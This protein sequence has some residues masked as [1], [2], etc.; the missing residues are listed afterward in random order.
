MKTILSFFIISFMVLQPIIGQTNQDKTLSAP[1]SADQKMPYYDRHQIDISNLRDYYDGLLIAD[2]MIHA[3]AMFSAEDK[4]KM[5]L[6][7]M[8]LSKSNHHQARSAYQLS[9]MD[10]PLREILA[11]WSPTYVETIQDPRMRA[12][13]EYLKQASQLP[14]KVNADTHAALRM[15]YTD[16]QIAELTDLTSVNAANAVHDH[17]LPIATDQETIDWALKNLAPV[18][19]SLGLNASNSKAEQRANPYV[20]ETLEKAFEEINS[21]WQR[22]NL[23]AID[24]E[25]ETDW[26][27]FLTGYGVSPVTFDADTDGVE[28]PFDAYPIDYS[29]WKK[30]G[31]EKESQPK[32]S[33]PEFNVAAY[34]YSYFQPA[35]V[36]KTRYPFSD[37]HLIDLEWTRQSSLGTLIM[38]SYLLIKD[39]ALPVKMKWSL[40]FIYQLASGCVHCQ[41]HGSFG[42]FQEFEAEYIGNKIPP[43]ELPTV[44][45]YIHNLMDFEQSDLFSDAQKAA[46]RLARD[47]GPMPSRNTAAHI[48]ELRRHYTDREIQEIIATLVLTGW[49]STSIQSQAC[50]T[51]RKSMSWA[52]TYL[53]PTGWNPGVHIGRP[54]EQRPYHMSQLFGAVFAKLSAGEVPDAAAEWIGVDI[55]LAVDSDGDGVEDYF[56]GFPQDPSRW[57]DTDRDGI[58]DSDD[59]DIDGDGLSNQREIFLGTFPYKADSDGDGIDDPTE[60]KAGTSPVDPSQF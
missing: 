1:P 3:D 38:D 27:N 5:T 11:I 13:F 23:A 54:K 60:I 47:A 4:W 28:D 26:I 2:V 48:E 35:T 53:T 31:Q 43:S 37:R 12:A 40:F 50:V 36:P 41:V 55:P 56:D 34:D 20:G 46:F 39:R 9:K 57:A 59:D 8:I 49:L 10:V 42:V 45:E 17:I 16:R 25:F 32:S 44:I 6:F 18:N 58:E 24:P 21:R 14:T 19:W 33:T 22:G 15:H 29:K 30:P 51:D 7:Q 52:L